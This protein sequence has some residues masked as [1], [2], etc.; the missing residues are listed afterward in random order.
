[1]GVTAVHTFV[2]ICHQYHR[3]Y[4]CLCRDI[5]IMPSSGHESSTVLTCILRIVHTVPRQLQ[6]RVRN[7]N[8][9]QL[10][11]S[12]RGILISASA[13]DPGVATN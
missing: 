9:D 2:G 8:E 1:M 12:Q 11:T 7:D 6:P 10:S 4:E 13:V 3:C 5:M